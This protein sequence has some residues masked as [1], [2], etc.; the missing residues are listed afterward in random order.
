MVLWLLLTPVASVQSLNWSYHLRRPSNRPPQV[1]TLTF[2]APL[3]HLLH[4]PLI[5]LGFVV[6]CQLAPLL[7][8]LMGFVSLKS[9]VC[10]RLP[11]DPASRRRP[12]LQLTV[13]AINLRKGLSPPSQRPCWAHNKK[14]RQRR[15][16]EPFGQESVTP[17]TGRTAAPAGKAHHHITRH[18]GHSFN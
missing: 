17:G 7:Q 2:P 12:C 1:R 15:G 11:S 10:P 18:R 13:G 3:P 6:C 14:P 5:A 9:Q 4:Q 8:P 16:S